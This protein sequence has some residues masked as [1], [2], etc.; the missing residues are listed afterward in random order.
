MFSAGGVFF[1]D[2]LMKTALR[3]RYL[4]MLELIAD[5]EFVIQLLVV[6]FSKII[7]NSLSS[8]E[9]NQNKMNQNSLSG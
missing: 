1:A 4:L 9:Q 8:K 2:A 5:M 6:L 3:S 7:I